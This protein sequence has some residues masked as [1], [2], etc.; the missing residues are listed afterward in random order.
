[1]HGLLFSGVATSALAPFDVSEFPEGSAYR[2][3][4]NTYNFL[5]VCVAC[6]CM[7][8]CGCVCVCRSIRLHLCTCAHTLAMRV[9]T[10]KCSS[11]FVR[12]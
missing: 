5:G 1:M 7:C 11:V 3:R 4:A 6:V 9:C 12:E 8:V 2:S 10:R